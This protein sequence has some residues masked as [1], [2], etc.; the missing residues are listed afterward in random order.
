MTKYENTNKNSNSILI[1]PNLPTK[2]NYD[3]SPINS[4]DV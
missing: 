4:L 3:D 2:N 1:S